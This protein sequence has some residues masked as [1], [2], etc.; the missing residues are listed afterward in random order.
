MYANM[1][2]TKS[3]N[4]CSEFP[5]NMLLVLG[6]GPLRPVPGFRVGVGANIR[7]TESANE[8]LQQKEDG[9]ERQARGG[10]HAL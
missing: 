5:S 2:F 1:T 8:P 7:V 6:R 9:E 10:Q 3:C 4:W